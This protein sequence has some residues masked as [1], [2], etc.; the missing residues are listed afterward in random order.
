MTMRSYL[1]IS[2]DSHVTEPPNVDID[3]IDPKYRDT[4]PRLQHVEGAGDIFVIEGLKVPGHP[5]PP[6]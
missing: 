2:A 3:H 5:V 1:V 4:A 6:S